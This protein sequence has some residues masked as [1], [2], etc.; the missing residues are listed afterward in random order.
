MFILLR[1]F[2]NA[3]TLRTASTAGKLDGLFL[4]EYQPGTPTKVKIILKYY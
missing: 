3:F 1:A 4:N 2:E